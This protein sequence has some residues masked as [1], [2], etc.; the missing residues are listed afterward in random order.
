MSSQILVDGLIKTT[1]A[2]REK[3]V[4]EILKI[5]MS[6]ISIKNNVVS[7]DVKWTL[8]TENNGEKRK[9]IVILQFCRDCECLVLQLLHM[10]SISK[11]LFEFLGTEQVTFVGVGILR[12]ML[13]LKKKYDLWC[14]LIL[15][16][17]RS[18][19]EHNCRLITNIPG[20]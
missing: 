11:S 19:D 12:I 2:R 15:T 8:V 3:E 18:I 5:F 17:V 14:K 13:E 9:A 7:L 16:K 1:V 10:A 6:I 4:N 20:Q